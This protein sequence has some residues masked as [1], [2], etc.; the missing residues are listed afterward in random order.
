MVK[1]TRTWA[2]VAKGRSEDESEI[3]DS[4]KSGKESKTINLVKMNDS[5][6]PNHMKAKQTRGQPKPTPMQRIQRVEGL[7]QDCELR[8]HSHKQRSHKLHKF[9][10]N[11]M[12]NEP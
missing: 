12:K 2:E 11:S 1:K 10:A 8:E 5:E 9:G 4:D 7:A 6:K 3:V